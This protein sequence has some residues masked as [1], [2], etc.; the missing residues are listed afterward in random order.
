MFSGNDYDIKR[1]TLLY[2]IWG[3][4]YHN[5]LWWKLQPKKPSLCLVVQRA[6]WV[7]IITALLHLVVV[8]IQYILRDLL[9]RSLRFIFRSKWAAIVLTWLIVVGL[10][11]LEGGYVLPI[12]VFFIFLLLGSA[13]SGLGVAWLIW[14]TM[15]RTIFRVLYFDWVVYRSCYFPVH[16]RPRSDLPDWNPLWIHVV[17][18]VQIGLLLIGSYLSGDYFLPKRGD[19]VSLL[20]WIMAVLACLWCLLTLPIFLYLESKERRYQKRYQEAQAR[21]APHETRPSWFDRIWAR[22]SEEIKPLIIWLKAVH[23]RVCPLV[24][25]ID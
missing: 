13:L 21:K 5:R 17:F 14:R 10:S 6:F 18:W 15:K 23:R 2:R 12:F 16:Q 7:G 24:N 8:P 4:T 22:L 25:F 20:L 9:Y 1:S 3:W 19:G 11:F